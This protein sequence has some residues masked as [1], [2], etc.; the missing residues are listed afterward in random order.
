MSTLCNKSS[1]KTGEPYKETGRIPPMSDSIYGATG[2]K[3][4][5]PP[6]QELMGATMS[7]A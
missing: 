4:F 7:F 3:K 6:M 2:E 1:D 5:A